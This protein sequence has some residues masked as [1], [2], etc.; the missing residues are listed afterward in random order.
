MTGSSE[1]DTNI[2]TIASPT[3]ASI[4]TTNITK[5]NH[6]I[7]IKLDNHNYLLWKTLFVPL[8]KGYDL[9][10]YVNGTLLCLAKFL[11]ST[12][13]DQN[14]LNPE[15]VAWNKQDNILLG[16]ILSSL[17]ATILAHV[18]GAATSSQAVWHALERKFASKSRAHI[19]TLRHELQT[20][21]KGT[22]KMSD[23]LQ[24]AK[25]L[26][27]NLAASGQIV[28]ELDLQQLILGGLPRPEY[29]AVYTTLTTTIDDTHM[30][31]FQAHLMAFE[32]RL[33]RQSVIVDT[34]P[35]SAN[36][37]T[38]SR[39]RQSHNHASSSQHQ[40]SF[41]RNQHSYRGRGRNNRGRGGR[42]GNSYYSHFG[43]HPQASTYGGAIQSKTSNKKKPKL[44]NPSITRQSLRSG[45][46]PPDASL[47]KGLQ[48]DLLPS[49]VS[50][51]P[52]PLN[53]GLGPLSFQDA[54]LGKGNSSQRHIVDTIMDMAEN[55]PLGY[56]FKKDLDGD[57]GSLD[58]RSLV[59][60]RENVVRVM[61]EKMM[62]VKF[63]PCNERSVIVVGNKVGN[64]GFWDADCKEKDEGFIG[65]NKILFEYRM[66][67]FTSSYDGFIRVIDIENELFNVVYSCDDCIFSLCQRP[68]EAKSIY[69]GEGR[70]LFNVWD[71][72]A[73]KSSS[74][75]MLHNRGINTI[76][77]NPG[78][79]NMMVTSSTDE[80][81][82]I[83]D[84][85]YI[86]SRRP[87]AL[88]TINPE[89]YVN[90]AYFSPSGNSLAITCF[91]DKVELLSGV[92]FSDRSMIYHDNFTGQWIAS[93]RLSYS[94]LINPLLR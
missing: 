57:V 74:S 35:I 55:A 64:V 3:M 56:S 31:N 9:E 28:P 79:T 86:N 14:T 6:L 46:I 33:D 63:L 90:S 1:S 18:V 8:L 24:L 84:L 44:E 69:F 15:Y 42:S 11:P 7:S 52:K 16:W 61:P 20:L 47:A 5:I 60:K 68:Y 59:L 93:F 88:K 37:A 48:E 75:M 43:N 13:V 17:D 71:E 54:S 91:G 58:L 34:T 27:D 29:D 12:S 39:G 45:G 49:H 89:S 53:A 94:S 40:L 23:Y 19:N 50:K 82:C 72:R 36:V 21:R 73:G 80:T 4:T 77:F 67:I 38:S 65:M 32:H 87:K 70:G 41:N 85:R 2:S 92:D 76:D 10:G 26:T 25:T 81:A 66:K 62:S 78:N 30:E 51:T 22:T 83:W